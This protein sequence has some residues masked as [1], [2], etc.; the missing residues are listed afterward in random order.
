MAIS[1]EFCS[2]L[3]WSFNP[4]PPPTFNL[5]LS[6]TNPRFSFVNKVN[7]SQQLCHSSSLSSS[8]QQLQ[9]PVVDDDDDDDDGDDDDSKGQ[10]GNL[11][12]EYGWQ[13]RKMVE[14]DEEMRSV[15]NIQAEAFHQPLI[16]FNDVFFQY[17]CLVAETSTTDDQE[18]Q[19]LVGVVDVTVFRDESVIKHL[20]E[21]NE[22]L[23]VSG[24]AVLRNFR[25]SIF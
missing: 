8:D 18:K 21:A 5:F 17:A 19:Q 7:K 11:V 4:N 15:A 23:Y 13:V 14:K 22:Y 1:M 12:K 3:P 16:F 9:E 6:I 24:I 10:F 20:S 2:Q 25:Y